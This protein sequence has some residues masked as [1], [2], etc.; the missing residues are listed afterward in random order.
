M[1][2]VAV[3][4]NT[5]AARA[6]LRQGD[7]ITEMAGDPVRDEGDLRRILRNS[8]PNETITLSGVRG[9]GTFEVDVRLGEMRTR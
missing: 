6:G 9:N 3:E 4:A 1:L 5:P 8:R 7:I 2:I